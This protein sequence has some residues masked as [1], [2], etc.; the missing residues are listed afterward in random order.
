MSTRKEVQDLSAKDIF[1]ESSAPFLSVYD[2]RERMS[3]LVKDFGQ[4]IRC[5]CCGQL[6]HIYPRSISS[7]IARVLIWLVRASSVSIAAKKGPWI[8][9][10]QVPHK[11]HVDHASL[12]TLRKFGLIEQSENSDNRKRNSGFW[13]P[14]FKGQ[15]FAQTNTRI[16]KYVFE[17][18]GKILAHSEETTS[19]LESLNERFDYKEL[20][21]APLEVGKPNVG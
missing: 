7:T 21:N 18:D 17:F 20:W 19:I 14:T 3:K 12:A 16:P 13:K 4:Q 6:V 1:G 10:T 9:K 11:L 15:Q 8:H 2:E 5:R